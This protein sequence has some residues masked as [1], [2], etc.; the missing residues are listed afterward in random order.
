MRIDGRPTA[1]QA[2]RQTYIH[3]DKQIDRNA[4]TAKYTSRQKDKINRHI[5]SYVNR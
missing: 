3:I 1:K 5:Y 4:Y 2:D